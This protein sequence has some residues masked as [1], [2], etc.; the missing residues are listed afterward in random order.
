MN[1]GCVKE[2]LEKTRKSILV[3]YSNVINRLIAWFKAKS[4]QLEEKINGKKFIQNSLSPKILNDKELEKIMPYIKRVHDGIINPDITNIALMGSYGSGKSTII[5]NFEENYPEYK[6]LN[7]SLGSYSKQ[8]LEKQNTNVEET[9][10][11]DDLN[12]KL[13]NSLVKQMIYREKNSKL[14]YSRFKKINHVSNR[15]KILFYFLFLTSLISFFYL[16]NY[17]NFKEIILSNVEGITNNTESFDLILYCILLTSSSIL[18]FQIFQ[19]VLKQFKLSKLNFANV[20]IEEDENNFSYFNKYIDEILYYFETNKFD[21]VVIEDVDRFK[22]VRVFEHL[23]ELNL[24]LNNSKQINRKITF[25]YAVKEDIFS[26]SK[27]DIEEHESEIRTKFFELIIPIIPVVD[28]FNSREYLVPMIKEKSE[29]ELSEKFEKFLKD[30]SLYISDLRLLTNIVNEFFTY[31]EIHRSLSGSMNKESL[32]SIIALKNLVPSTFTDLQKS[33]G[34]IYETIVK[35]KYDDELI[36]DAHEELIIIETEFQKIEEEISIDKVSEIK[37]FLFDQG[38]FNLDKIIVDRNYMSLI[39]FDMKLIET[40]LESDEENI[41]FEMWNRSNKSISKSKFKQIVKEKDSVLKERREKKQEEYDLKRAELNIFSRATLKQKLKSYPTLMKLIYAEITD[42]KYNNKDKDFILYILSNG[43]LAE[44]YSTYLS[45]FYEKSMTID[46]KNLLIKLKSNQNIEFDGKVDNLEG[47]IN[48]FLPQDF[49]KQGIHNINILKYL[50]SNSFKDQHKIRDVVLEKFFIQEQAI[51]LESL[52]I[53]L[54]EDKLNIANLVF[55]LFRK[56]TNDFIE[57]CNASEK[58]RLIDLIF[59]VCLGDITLY[60]GEG[61][62]KKLLLQVL[63]KQK[64][65]YEGNEDFEGS[66]NATNYVFL[67]RENILNRPNFFVEIEEYVESNIIMEVLSEHNVEAFESA[68]IYFDDIKLDN[69]SKERYNKFIHCELYC[70][71]Q[72][73]FSEILNYKNQDELRA[74]SYAN[75]LNSKIDNLIK[76]TNTKLIDFVNEVLFS[77]DELSETE[78]SFLSLINSE[79]INDSDTKIKLITKSNVAVENIK[80]VMDSSLW[81]ILLEQRKCSITWENIKDYYESVEIDLTV[82]NSIFTNEDDVN[83]LKKQYDESDSKDKL[84]ALLKKMVDNKSIV[85]TERNIELLGITTYDAGELTRE[86]T[87]ILARNNLIDFNI[88]NL[89]KFKEDGVIVKVVLNHLDDFLEN[90]SE[91]DLSEEE[92][93]SLI[94]NWKL[95]SIEELLGTIVNGESDDFFQNTKL[96]EILLE[97]EI[98]SDDKLFVKLLENIDVECLKEYFI[99]NLQEMTLSKSIIEQMLSSFLV[100]NITDFSVEDYDC[101]FENLSNTQLFVDLLNNLF[102]NKKLNIISVKAVTYWLGT[103]S[104]PISELYIDENGKNKVVEIENISQNVE[105]LNNLRSIGIVS[106]F[107]EKGDSTIK[108]NMRRKYLKS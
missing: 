106:T 49:E 37:K 47:F 59:Y 12:E 16:N 23:K 11:I 45:I 64:Q 73:I 84:K 58:N 24:L 95:E 14:P 69:L 32:F 100:N 108:V 46:D 105:L 33:Q 18:L 101:I 57:K 88:E 70:Y 66:K 103:Q 72:D 93:I 6:V 5:R 62:R 94:K 91:I 44:D 51:Y 17:L 76:N 52:K 3:L 75:V 15:K 39:N 22:S 104:K 50:F 7:L 28:T 99:F 78:D 102:K 4:N 74:V 31:L 38:I 48:E 25:V 27:E 79:K 77:L 43:Y 42:E 10:D 71:D 55:E 54:A 21:V 90:Y 34:F 19:T 36:K 107:N 29:E 41:A 85:V 89:S 20:S 96:V 97:R 2:L 63:N 86:S 1:K 13:E 8:G 65:V 56:Y 82:I 81:A 67:I 9:N 35:G 60:Y 87:H 61:D 26:N 53:I 92:M 80:Q 83:S 68:K 40:I 98:S 30:I